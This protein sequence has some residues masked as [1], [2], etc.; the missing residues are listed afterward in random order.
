MGLISTQT[1]NKNK[2]K[3]SSIKLLTLLNKT[4]TTVY[5][6]IRLRGGLDEWMN[7]IK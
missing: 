4:N 6:Y 5:I 2:S 1:L 3:F 7:E